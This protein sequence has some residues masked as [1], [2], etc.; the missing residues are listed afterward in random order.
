MLT[1]QTLLDHV[2]ALA[3]RDDDLAAVVEAF[4]P[5]PLWERDEGFGTLL[6]LI[7]EQQVSLA[8]ARAAFDRCAA[9]LGGPPTPVGLLALTDEELRADGFSRQKTRYARVLADALLAG[10]LDLEALRALDDDAVRAALTALPGIGPW[11]A[12]V[13]LVMALRRGDAF[14]AGDLALQVAA[15]ELKRLAARPTPAELV[16]LAEPWRPHR[17][18]AARILWQHYLG[19]RGR[20]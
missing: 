2:A 17:A 8:S 20:L 9:R 5:P 18:V 4:G 16:A 19:T 11:T 10:M 3:A 13:Y 7:L 12:D 15:Q 6:L 1:H 14:P